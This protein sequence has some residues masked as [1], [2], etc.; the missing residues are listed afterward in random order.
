MLEILA[1]GVTSQKMFQEATTKIMNEMNSSAETLAE[2]LSVKITII[3][4]IINLFK[5]C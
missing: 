2:Y 5:K 3:L 1:N 4:T